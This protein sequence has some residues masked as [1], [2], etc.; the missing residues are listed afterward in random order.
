[1]PEEMQ[2]GAQKTKMEEREDEILRFRNLG[3]LIQQK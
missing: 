1:M 2:Q 3:F